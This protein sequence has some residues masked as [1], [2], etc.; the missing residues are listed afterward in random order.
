MIPKKERIINQLLGC[1]YIDRNDNTVYKLNFDNVLKTLISNDYIL[2]KSEF[3]TR[4]E[5]VLNAS[6]AGKAKVGHPTAYAIA[7]I[8]FLLAEVMNVSKDDIT[9]F[10]MH[11]KKVFDKE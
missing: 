9:R 4:V 7:E 8:I 2:H 5:D 6:L 1:I 3:E 10:Q 11:G